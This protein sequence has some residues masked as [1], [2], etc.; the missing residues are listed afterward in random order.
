LRT[1][2]RKELLGETDR[3]LTVVRVAAAHA[4]PTADIAQMLAEVARG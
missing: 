2:L 1:A 4:Y 3:K